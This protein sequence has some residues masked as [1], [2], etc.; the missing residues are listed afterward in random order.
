MCVLIKH[1]SG[2]VFLGIFDADQYLPSFKIL[3]TRMTTI[4]PSGPILCKLE[5]NIDK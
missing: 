2:S 4:H 5:L 1:S 3:P